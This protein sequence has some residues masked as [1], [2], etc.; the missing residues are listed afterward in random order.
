MQC[1]IRR[2]VLNH[3]PA[4]HKEP[5]CRPS[6]CSK[7]VHGIL[8]A[9]HLLIQHRQLLSFV[10]SILS[11]RFGGIPCASGTPNNLAAC[12]EIRQLHSTVNVTDHQVP[13]Q[14]FSRAVM[15]SKGPSLAVLPLS[16]QIKS[17]PRIHRND[18]N[19]LSLHNTRLSFAYRRNPLHARKSHA[20]RRTFGEVR[21]KLG[22]LAILPS[23]HK[24]GLIRPSK[25]PSRGALHSHVPEHASASLLQVLLLHMNT[26]IMHYHEQDSRYTSKQARE[27]HT[28]ISGTTKKKTHQ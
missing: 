7:T 24:N 3:E 21:S 16:F 12:R 5:G 28:K 25:P 2:H 14:R 9:A 6:E 20:T 26:R 22:H 27:Y 8:I 10:R 23:F 1:A 19:A 4:I 17:A 11:P 15:F 18:V 13:A